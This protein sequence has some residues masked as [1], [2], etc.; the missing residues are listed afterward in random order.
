MQGEVL[1]V[2]E[3]A[4]ARM[5]CNCMPTQPTNW[6]CEAA[7]ACLPVH[8]SRAYL[9]CVIQGSSFKYCLNAGPLVAAAVLPG[10][11]GAFHLI[12]KPAAEG[13]I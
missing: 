1:L 9:A 2:C 10:E 4:V 3:L 12:R 13:P 5:S 8:V 6:F 11:H 7:A